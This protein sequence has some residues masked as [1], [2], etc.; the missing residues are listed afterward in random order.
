M[1]SHCLHHAGN[2]FR[3]VY[4]FTF[5]NRKHSSSQNGNENYNRIFISLWYVS[6]CEAGR[7]ELFM[8]AVE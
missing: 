2:D 4:Y 7:L 3:S 8:I 6:F 5:Q 1:E